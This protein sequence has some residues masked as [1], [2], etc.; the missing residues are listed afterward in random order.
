MPVVNRSYGV[1]NKNFT[2]S[3]TS[4]RS[5]TSLDSTANSRCCAQNCTVLW[6]FNMWR[7]SAA[8]NTKW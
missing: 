1:K 3:L 7:I 8:S 5:K 4:S 2:F 6:W